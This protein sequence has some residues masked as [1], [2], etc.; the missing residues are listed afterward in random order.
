V[1]EKHDA[2]VQVL[3]GPSAGQW[4]TGGL[5]AISVWSIAMVVVLTMRGAGQ[6]ALPAILTIGGIGIVAL[7]IALVCTWRM[8]RK[9]ALELAAGYTTRSGHPEV[10]QVDPQS[11][12]LIRNANDP[13]LSRAEYRAA[14]RRVRMSAQRR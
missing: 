6:G 8:K 4:A 5:V 10:P 12:G 11:Q 14:I 3:A 2:H 9:T 7:A 13:D 1:E